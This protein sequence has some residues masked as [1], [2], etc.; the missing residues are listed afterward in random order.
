MSVENVLEVENV[1]DEVPLQVDL[2]NTE[3]QK[4]K[5]KKNVHQP[6]TMTDEKFDD[7]L[8]NKLDNDQSIVRVEPEK[9]DELDMNAIGSVFK[10]ENE[11]LQQ[12]ENANLIAH[13]DFGDY[14]NIAKTKFDRGKNMKTIEL[15]W[16]VWLTT[17][18]G[19]SESYSRHHREMAQLVL[20]YPK[21]K[22][23]AMTFT[24]LHRLKKQILKVFSTNLNISEWWKN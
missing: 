3:K 8:K 5:K 15:T 4:G 23:L 16:A 7:Y 24:E 22:N 9:L 13:L 10:E 11:K 17:N 19:I 6:S 21:L 1:V 2:Q 18:V 14:L 12:N 20:T